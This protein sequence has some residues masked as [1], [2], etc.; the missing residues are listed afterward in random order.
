M[1]VTPS[2]ISSTE[3]ELDPTSKSSADLDPT[4]EAPDELNLDIPEEVPTADDPSS[5]AANR[6]TD[7]AGFT[8]E[9]FASLLSK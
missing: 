3:A 6:D 9:E 7:G 5:R 8:L 4:S 2:E 1:T